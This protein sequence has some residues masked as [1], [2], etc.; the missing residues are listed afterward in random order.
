MTMLDVMTARLVDGLVVANVK[1]RAKEFEITFSKDG[2]T[3]KGHLPKVCAPGTHSLV[4]DQTIFNAM[5]A[6]AFQFHDLDGA[7]YWLEKCMGMEH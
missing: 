6:F 3:V 5:A 1:E 7:R 2:A 4:A